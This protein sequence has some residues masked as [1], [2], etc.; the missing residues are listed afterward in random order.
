MEIPLAALTAL[1][2]VR[3]PGDVEMPLAAL[4]ALG[5]VRRPGCCENSF[6]NRLD[7]VL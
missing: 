5:P 6:N 4:T 7:S 1:G 3:R 2:P